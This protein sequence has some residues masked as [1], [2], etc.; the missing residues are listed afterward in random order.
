M[1]STLLTL[2]LAHQVFALPSVVSQASIP[3]QPKLETLRMN[4]I[5]QLKLLLPGPKLVVGRA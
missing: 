1:Q 3:K 4:S 2:S 5:R